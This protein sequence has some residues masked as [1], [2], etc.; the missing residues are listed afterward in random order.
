VKQTDQGR[1]RVRPFFSS[2]RQP[3]R[4]LGQKIGWW[5]QPVPY[6]ATSSSLTWCILELAS[7]YSLWFFSIANDMWDHR[8]WIRI[9]K[10]NGGFVNLHPKILVGLWNRHRIWWFCDY[11][12]KVLVGLWNLLLLVLDLWFRNRREKIYRNVIFSLKYMVH[13]IFLILWKTFKLTIYWISYGIYNVK[14]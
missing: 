1:R 3:V 4:R 12:A 9:I 2:S 10:N 14:Y 8:Y 5:S 6:C 11:K 7:R 13:H